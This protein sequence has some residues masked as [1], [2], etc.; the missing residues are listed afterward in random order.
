MS[1]ASTLSSRTAVKRIAAAAAGPPAAVV[2]AAVSV[3]QAVA[4]VVGIAVFVVVTKINGAEVDS[5][6]CVSSGL[7]VAS[8]LA[9]NAA[10]LVGAPPHR[11]LV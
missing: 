10:R 5:E 8:T 6:P 7:V 3:A 11:G 9:G 4:L 1:K 2:S